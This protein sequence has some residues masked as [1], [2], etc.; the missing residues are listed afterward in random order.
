M[1]QKDITKKGHLEKNLTGLVY[2]IIFLSTIN[3][4]L[5]F[6]ANIFQFQHFQANLFNKFQVTGISLRKLWLN[7]ETRIFFMPSVDFGAIPPFVRIESVFM[8]QFWPS[9]AQH[10]LPLLKQFSGNFIDS[11]NLHLN[12]SIGTDYYYYLNCSKSFDE[13]FKSEAEFV[14]CLPGMLEI[15]EQCLPRLTFC[16]NSPQLID[17]MFL[18]ASTLE[19]HSVQASDN[20]NLLI[21]TV[22][23]FCSTDYPYQNKIKVISNWMHRQHV[24]GKPS[25]KPTISRS[26]T[27]GSIEGDNMSIISANCVRQL[28]EI[29][30]LVSL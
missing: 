7:Y 30:K 5:I 9:I 15:F 23:G 16:V 18:I 3:K 14:S 12:G 17:T 8:R 11:L 20:V 4:F 26:L 2:W 1:S 13:S 19:L 22:R 10:L 29:L 6:K 21:P 28:I 27:I 24:S 25:A